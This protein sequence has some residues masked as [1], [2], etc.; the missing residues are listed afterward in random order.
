[1]CNEPEVRWLHRQHI[2]C[3]KQDMRAS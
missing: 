3:N 2:L 1:M